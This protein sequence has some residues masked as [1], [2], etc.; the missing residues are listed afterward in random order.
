MMA[1]HYG[2]IL[3]RV[4]LME[5][6]VPVAMMIGPSPD[7]QRTYALVLALGT[8]GQPPNDFTPWIADVPD[9][10]W[11]NWIVLKGEEWTSL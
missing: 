5:H 10:D 8:N 9:D 2:T 1:P 7:S 4:V 6:E 3:A 11:E